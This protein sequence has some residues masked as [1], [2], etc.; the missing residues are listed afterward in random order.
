MRK[1]GFIL[2]WKSLMHTGG[3]LW[4]SSDQV[5]IKMISCFWSEPVDD[6]LKISLEIKVIPENSFHFY[7]CGCPPQLLFFFLLEGCVVA[8]FTILRWCNAALFISVRLIMEMCLIHFSFGG[9]FRISW[10]QIWFTCSLFEPLSCEQMFTCEIGQDDNK[11]HSL[12]YT[13]SNISAKD[14]PVSECVR[15]LLSYL[16]VALDLQVSVLHL[17]AV[18]GMAQTSERGRAPSLSFGGPL[19]LC[20]PRLVHGGVRR[21]ERAARRAVQARCVSLT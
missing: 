15:L 11:I 6:K 18:S 19:L 21:W 5:K 12:F 20:L 10:P 17:W 13:M 14:F 3:S 8:H 7:S 16:V 1:V 9:L 4:V 2:F